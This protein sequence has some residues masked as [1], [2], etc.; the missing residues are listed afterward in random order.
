MSGLFTPDD[1]KDFFS[2]PS[3]SK[4][5]HSLEHNMDR[6]ISNIRKKDAGDN[7]TVRHQKL[8]ELETMIKQ[9]KS[10][11]RWKSASFPSI[12]MIK[13]PTLLLK[14]ALASFMI[15]LGIYF[16]CLAFS[17]MDSQKP[18]EPYRAVFVVYIVASFLGLLI[19]YVPS[20]FKELE[21]S[22]VRRRAQI[23]TFGI[24]KLDSEERETL[25]SIRALL[26]SNAQEFREEDGSDDDI[27]WEGRLE[28]L[29]RP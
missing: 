29:D 14:Y 2:K 4:G 12:L 28:E 25:Q 3:N 19:Y 1:V 18:R 8:I 6:L 13:A 9:F 17:D 15:G 11:N 27:S 16:G 26:N 10:R 5:L 7:S 23:M 20:I 22:A 21:F 24:E